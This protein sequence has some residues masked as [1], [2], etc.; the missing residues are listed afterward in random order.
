MPYGSSTVKLN[1]GISVP[2]RGFQSKNW[3]IKVVPRIENPSLKITKV[4]FVD[5]FF[6]CKH[7]KNTIIKIQNR[8]RI[9]SNLEVVLE[10]L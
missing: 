6:Y 1:T 7:M 5:G 2:G 4:I 9:I 8:R 10:R 3:K